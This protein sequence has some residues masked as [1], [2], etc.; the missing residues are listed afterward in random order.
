MADFIH[1]Q[2]DV[3]SGSSQG[4]IPSGSPADREHLLRDSLFPEDSYS[5]P[6]HSFSA[7]R[8]AFCMLTCP[9]SFLQPPTECTGLTCRAPSGARG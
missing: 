7:R 9:C 1:E 6:F 5:A 2:K 8:D 4:S 3:P